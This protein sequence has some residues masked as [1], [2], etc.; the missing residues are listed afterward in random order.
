MVFNCLF[1]YNLVKRK[2]KGISLRDIFHDVPV[3][4]VLTFGE[5]G[6]YSEVPMLQ[7]KTLIIAAVYGDE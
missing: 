2:S 4:G 6:S 1:Y 5:V 3:F 7:N